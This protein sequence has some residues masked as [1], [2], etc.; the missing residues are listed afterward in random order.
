MTEADLDKEFGGRRGRLGRALPGERGDV[1]KYSMM[2]QR[3]RG[4]QQ[5]QVEA[6]ERVDEDDEPLVLLQS[7][8]EKLRE[9]LEKERTPAAERAFSREI[10]RLSGDASIAMRPN[11]R[12]RA[13]NTALSKLGYGEKYDPEA[14]AVHREFLQVA[15]GVALKQ[16]EGAGR[17][18]AGCA[19]AEA[20]R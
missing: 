13:L 9:D 12:V 20:T 6:R 1:T 8:F 7:S 14:E 4:K 2:L 11:A 17:P 5:P 10:A 19:I 3:V 18:R 16:M 15:L